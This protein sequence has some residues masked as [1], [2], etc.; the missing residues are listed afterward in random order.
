M[1]ALPFGLIA[2]IFAVFGLV[3]LASHSV[4]VFMICASGFAGSIVMAAFS[5]A[6]KTERRP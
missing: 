1:N 5:L 2:A 6:P 4:A 3:A